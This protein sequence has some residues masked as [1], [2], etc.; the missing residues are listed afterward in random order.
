MN[1]VVTESPNTKV[2]VY[3]IGRGVIRPTKYVQCFG[4]L[5]ILLGAC[6]LSLLLVV[7]A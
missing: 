4:A 5:V 2:A 1:T 7:T 3:V 6:L